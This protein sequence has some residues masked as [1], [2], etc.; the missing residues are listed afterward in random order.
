[1]SL[2][3][4]KTNTLRLSLAVIISAF[5]VEITIGTF[6]NS[7]ALITDS[8]HAVLDSIVTAILLVAAR[9]A[10]KPPDREH[11]YGHGKIETMGSFTGAI[12]ILLVAVFFV[13]ESILRMQGPPP[14]VVPG[15][16]AVG[17]AVYTL[18]SD[19]FRMGI[20]RR[21][22][23]KTEGS[24]LRVDFYH[25]FMDMSATSVALVGILFVTM[26]Y[27]QGDYIA[28][29][30]LGIFLAVLSIKLIHKTALELT[31]AI[32]AG[33]VR[34]VQ[35]IV[36]KTDGVMNTESVQM[37]R[38]GNEI[39]AEVKISL[40][41]AASFEEAHKISSDVEKNIKSS[42]ANSNVTV[43]FEPTWK[44]VPIDYKV[45]HVASAVKGVE[46]IHNV[47]YTTS[48]EG[49]FISLHVMV[50][51]NM[52]LEEAHKISD[53]IETQIR[54][55]VPNIN[56]ITIHLEPYV[57]IP[58]SLPVEDL[59]I[60]E[61]IT[62]TIKEYPAVK[63]IGR[64]ITFQLQDIFKI[65]IDC[66]FDGN[67]SVERVHDIVSEIEFKIKNQI[68]NAVITIHPEPS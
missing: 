11:T 22:L 62:K 38:S 27:Y 3:N 15:I 56:H 6:S 18:C 25:A 67:L 36:N 31:D 9:W 24:T 19:I 58:K 50:D 34:Q 64:V 12:I 43:H 1:M 61:Q 20:L 30:I 33:M 52:H 26:G 2:Q 51:K 42:I 5:V 57:A 45:I 59:S 37:R 29:L 39:F 13:Y 54:N 68:K 16:M 63:K 66:S 53:D 41:G 40:S 7:L 55:A 8:V 4:L 21:A 47:D 48:G 17:A 49:L 65:D 23:K 14:T 46:G 28:A 60:E 44:D 10:A 35:D 32:P